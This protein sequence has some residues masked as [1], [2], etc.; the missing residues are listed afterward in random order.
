M[1]AEDAMIINFYLA[2]SDQ[3]LLA[4][5]RRI[6]ESR[7]RSLSFVVREALESYCLAKG[8]PGRP[9][10]THRR[11]LREPKSEE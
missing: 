4:Q 2:E 7:R 3:E 9:K 11:A 1:V 6:S 5:V 8:R 10:P